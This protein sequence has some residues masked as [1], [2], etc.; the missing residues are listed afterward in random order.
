MHSKHGK[1]AVPK[2]LAILQ[3]QVFISS[4]V[5]GGML[6]AQIEGLFLEDVITEQAQKDSRNQAHPVEN[7]GGGKRMVSLGLNHGLES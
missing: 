1:E 6:G 7:P 3:A 5:N 2:E 4:T